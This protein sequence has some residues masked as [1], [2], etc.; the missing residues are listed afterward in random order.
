MQIEGYDAAHMEYFGVD[1][2]V[3][4]ASVEGPEWGPV[5][6]HP[7]EENRREALINL[8]RSEADDRG[9]GLPADTPDDPDAIWGAL[10]ARQQQER[11]MRQPHHLWEKWRATEEP[12]RN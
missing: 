8:L 12:R 4:R 2:T 10:L 1:G 11:E 5:T 6:L 9:L 7:T 3:Y